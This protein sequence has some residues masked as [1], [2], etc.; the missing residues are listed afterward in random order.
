MKVKGEFRFPF[1]EGDLRQPF[2]NKSMEPKVKPKA[3][4][5]ADEDDI[6]QN[7]NMGQSV[8]NQRRGSR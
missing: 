4:E 1:A 6:L 3:I 8:R 2:G 5:D 7:G